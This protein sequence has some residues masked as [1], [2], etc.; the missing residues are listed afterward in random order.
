MTQRLIFEVEINKVEGAGITGPGL[1]ELISASLSPES[2][3][4]SITV[5]EID[6]AHDIRLD[7]QNLL[8]AISEHD[9]FLSYVGREI[10][11][12]CIRVLDA[13]AEREREAYA[14]A[15][16]LRQQDIE[17]AN[18]LGLDPGTVPQVEAYVCAR[19]V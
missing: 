1:C 15:E 17:R 13:T 5:R 10:V 18:Q 8:T 4:V 7:V 19:G 12:D 11:D 16:L 14:R 2:P 6:P 9:V 3:D